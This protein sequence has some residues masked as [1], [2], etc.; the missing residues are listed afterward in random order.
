[1]VLGPFTLRT[2]SEPSLVAAGSAEP[3]AEQ[4]AQRDENKEP[5]HQQE[6]LRPNFRHVRP[7]C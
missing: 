5:V 6:K 4:R 7:E 2:S 1:M 3:D